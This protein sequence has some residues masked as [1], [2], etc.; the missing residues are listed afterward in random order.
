MISYKFDDK[1]FNFRVAGLVIHNGKILIHKFEN[2]DFWCLPGGRA[3]LMEDSITTLGREFQE[4]LEADVSVDRMLWCCE[5][6][7][8]HLGYHVHEICHYF[9]CQMEPDHEVTKQT[10]AFERQEL[11]GSWMTFLWLPL[12]ELEALNFYPTFIKDHIMSLP[13][14][15]Q[16][17]IDKA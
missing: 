15:T 11:D 9:L 12:N 3:E 16:Y 5:S 13:E 8:D 1:K 6:F 14:T 4:E 7:Y 2:Q 10:K 17:I